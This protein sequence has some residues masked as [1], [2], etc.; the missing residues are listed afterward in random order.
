MLV[1]QDLGYIPYVTYLMLHKQLQ[2]VSCVAHNVLLNSSLL[3]IKLFETLFIFPLRSAN[4]ID[5]R[6]SPG[7]CSSRHF[8]REK[9]VGP[10]PPAARAPLFLLELYAM[11]QK[12]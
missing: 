7:S 9:T 12:K 1:Q 11:I 8:Q 3:C 5:V 10:A 2:R 6:H 4:A